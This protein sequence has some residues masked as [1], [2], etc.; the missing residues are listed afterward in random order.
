MNYRDEVPSGTDLDPNKEGD[1]NT[2]V[3][4]KLGYRFAEDKYEISLWAKNAFDEDY[5]S[6]GFN[7]VLRE[8]SISSFHKEPRTYGLTFRANFDS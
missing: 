8:G 7:S 4:A 2:L 1:A 5:K 3:N 6:G